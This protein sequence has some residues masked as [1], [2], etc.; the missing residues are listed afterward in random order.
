M[1]SE[2]PSRGEA[3][4]SDDYFPFLILSTL[5]LDSP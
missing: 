3:Y 2:L 4:L 1:F 5:P